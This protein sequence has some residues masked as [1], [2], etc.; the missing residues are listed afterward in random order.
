MK[1]FRSILTV[2][3]LI[4]LASPVLWAADPIEFS[5]GSTEA[6]IRSGDERVKISEGAR[7]T[8][9]DITI[10]AQVI[11]VSGEGYSYLECTG[12]VV[13][14]DAGKGIEMSAGTITYDRNES[15]LLS[16]EQT[17]VE[18]KEK[19]IT[20][21]AGWVRYQQEEGILTF[22]DNVNLTRTTDD[23]IMVCTAETVT[24]VRSSGTV[25]LD[26]G[27]VVTWKNDTYRATTIR[28]NLDTDEITMSGEIRGTI[29]G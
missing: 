24:Y 16:R 29:N 22:Q 11:D 14:K 1:N 9:G 10:T 28:V 8:T 27:A 4:G 18:D 3:F 21:Q 19:G 2:I 17:S 5:G 13:L 25:M 6:I 12:D 23:G 20:A 15:I 7:V 26:G